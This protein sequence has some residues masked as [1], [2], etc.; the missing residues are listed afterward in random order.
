MSIDQC[1]LVVNSYTTAVILANAS[2]DINF[3]GLCFAVA[4]FLRW[5][6]FLGGCSGGHRATRGRCS[7]AQHTRPRRGCQRLAPYRD[8]CN[9]WIP[10]QGMP[11]HAVF[12]AN[13]CG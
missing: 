5:A 12:A 2:M 6:G 10:W 8:T 13:I 4:G 7:H 9:A 1:V 3:Y 11:Y